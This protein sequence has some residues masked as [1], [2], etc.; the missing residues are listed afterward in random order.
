M[1]DY[2][3]GNYS[4][5]SSKWDF[6]QMNWNAGFFTTFKCVN[7]KIIDLD[8][9]LKRLEFSLKE[10]KLEFPQR[11]YSKIL[12][13]LLNMNN[14]QDARFKLMIFRHD[15]ELNIWLQCLP[16]TINMQP[17]V[18]QVYPITRKDE[19]KYRF[20]SINYDKNISLNK[21]AKRRGFDD[22]LFIDG[23]MRVLET[24]FCNIFLA[25]ENEICT[26]LSSLPILPGTVRHKILEQRQ[27]GVHQVSEKE[28][29]LEDLPNYRYAFVT[30]AIHDLVVVKQIGEV[31]FEDS[32]SLI[33]EILNQCQE[34]EV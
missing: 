2:F 12:E 4:E 21:E 20:K 18:L 8:L 3:N 13:N 7:A 19:E 23:K 32:S 24:T 31:I 26:P 22:F 15:N 33:V 11:E 25:T 6:N 30:N 34:K 1:I 27:F 10:N 29:Y 16:L 28:I 17:K 9:H 5:Q 14:L